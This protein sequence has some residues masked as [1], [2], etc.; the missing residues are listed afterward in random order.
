MSAWLRALPLLAL[1][2]LA[3]GAVYLGGIDADVGP[4]MGA[5]WN[6][7]LVAMW[8]AFGALIA[9]LGFEA[10]R[11]RQD[12][13]QRAPAARLSWRLLKRLALLV[14][15]PLGMLFFFSLR[16]V[17]GAVD[18]WFRVDVAAA[19][20]DSLAVAQRS[21]DV[22]ELRALS[23]VRLHARRI[24]GGEDGSDDLALSEALGELGALELTLYSGSRQILARAAADPRFLL[25]IPPDD[26]LWRAARGAG[27]SSAVD[28]SGESLSILALGELPSRGDVLLARFAVDG[29]VALLAQRIEKQYYDYRQLAFLRDALKFTLSVV[30]SV[31]LVAAVLFALYLAFALARGLVAPLRQLVSATRAVAQGDYRISVPEIADDEIGGLGRAFNQM[32]RELELANQRLTR[33]AGDAE[34]GRRYFEGVLDRISSGVLS[35]DGAGRLRTSNGA[36]QEILGVDLNPWNGLAIERLGKADPPLLPLV[37]RLVEAL[38]RQPGDWREEVRIQRGSQEQR[39]LLRGARLPGGD[40]EVGGLVAVFEDES[41][42]ARAQRDSAWSEV[43]RRLAHEIKNPLTPIQLAAER[44]R[45][46]FLERL[47]E[48]DREILDR[49]THTIVAQVEALKAMVNAFSDYA[50]PPRLELQA[51]RLSRVIREVVDLY[52][53]ETSRVDIELHLPEDELP[54]RADAGRVRQLLHNL[55]RNAEEAETGGRARAEISLY[56]AA[57]GSRNFLEMEFRDHGPGIPDGLIERLFEPYTTTKA[58]G[59]GLGLAIVKKIVDEH[60]GHIR[61]DNL[62]DGGARFRI[63]FPL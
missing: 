35:L 29:E 58:K 7:V 16:F 1:A 37:Q 46:K 57:E 10:W 26:T 60:G 42:Y 28:R 27:S 55:L 23:S 5:E 30:L 32:A 22:S 49:S 12:L 54:V 2:V 53:G 11:L 38:A 21:I 40:G 17:H 48:G 18:G 41:E 14:L 15:P 9:A 50:R 61:V 62:S 52:A 47:P 20:E 13:R 39:L 25:P 34:A 8:L 36:A 6:L 45:R 51:I 19:L 4:R 3:L 24:D 63:R 56:G 59:T 31:V 43:A 44:L 33:A